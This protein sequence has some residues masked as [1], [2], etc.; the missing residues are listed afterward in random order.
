VRRDRPLTVTG[1]ERELAVP[2][3]PMTNTARQFAVST[4]T[5]WLGAAGSVIPDD[6]SDPD[7]PFY[8]VGLTTEDALK[9]SDKPT[10][11]TVR[12]AQADYP[13]RRIQT[14]ADATLAVELQEWSSQNFQAAFG[15][16]SVS[17]AKAAAPGP[18]ATP[19]IYKYSPPPMGGRIELACMIDVRDGTRNYRVVFPRTLQIDGAELALPK[20]KE[21]VLPLSLAVLGASGV[22]PW[23]ILSDDPAM[24]PIAA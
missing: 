22:D 8:A 18:P 6:L 23:Y 11:E 14:T 7:D 2:L 5:V 1:G 10:F 24:E 17:I 20:G 15:G 13:T 21:S 19:A 3:I 9:F 4:Y 16:G 12:S